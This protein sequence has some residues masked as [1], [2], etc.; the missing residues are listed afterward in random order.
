[1]CSS[2]LQIESYAEIFRRQVYGMADQDPKVV[3]E[4]VE[5]TMS[6]ASQL[7]EV[8]LDLTFFLKD[9]LKIDG[10]NA[11]AMGAAAAAVG[12]GSALGVPSLTVTLADDPDAIAKRLSAIDIRRQSMIARQ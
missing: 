8:G 5:I 1:M 12:G 9:L 6:S 7:K 3:T 10:Q 11:S 4:A 2:D